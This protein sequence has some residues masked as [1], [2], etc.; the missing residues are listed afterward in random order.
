[1]SEPDPV[2][3]VALIVSLVALILTLLQ[4][5]QQ[6]LA[7]SYDYR[8]CSNQTVGG[9]SKRSRRKFLWRELRFEVLFST[10][11]INVDVLSNTIQPSEKDIKRSIG[12]SKLSFSDS[13]SPSSS[14][15]VP[16]GDQVYTTSQKPWFLDLRGTRPQA[17]CSWLSLLNDTSA[18][19]LKIGIREHLMSYDFMPDGIKKPVAR[20]DRKSYLTLMSLFQDAIKRETPIGAG[21]YCEVT[22]HKLVNFGTVVS[23]HAADVQ[24]ARIYYIVSEKARSAMFNHFHLGF[25][26][27]LTHS[28]EEVYRSVL[29]FVDESAASTVRNIN[30]NNNGWSPGLAEVIGCFA[31]PEMP[32][33]VEHGTDS[34]LSIF[35]ARII[36]CILNDYPVV[37]LL[38]GE[39]IDYSTPDAEIIRDWATGYI[40]FSSTLK[41]EIPCSVGHGQNY[42]ALKFASTYFGKERQKGKP[43]SWSESR[44]ALDAIRLLDRQLFALVQREFARLQIRLGCSLFQD[45]NIAASRQPKDHG[46]FWRN[47]IG[48]VVATNYIKIC[49]VLG[50]QYPGSREEVRRA[51]IINRLMRGVLWQIHNGN[52]SSDDHGRQLECR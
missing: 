20:M 42:S 1:M 14:A 2:S 41:K 38:L 26:I 35:S 28:S 16:K 11:I 21:P 50:E 24:P 15:G 25:H 37:K 39:S 13:L 45:T 18:T 30:A 47:F 33:A 34:F 44:C 9:W 27:I 4:V 17:K 10:P 19:Q 29:A 23:Y 3:L 49:A 8:H 22:S 32:K 36:G 48:P 51:F 43:I 52:N 5:A 12:L 40:S 6:Y 7:T 46:H 31:E